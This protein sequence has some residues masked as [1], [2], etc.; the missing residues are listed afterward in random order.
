M[1][2]WLG[3]HVTL[4]VS[5]PHHKSPPCQVWWSETLQQKGCFAFNLS[6]ELMW[7]RDQRVMGHYRWAILIISH[8]PAKFG[9]HRRSAR[10]DISFLVCHM[11]LRY[12]MVRELRDVKREFPLSQVTTVQSS[13]IKDLL[14]EE[15]LSFYHVTWR[16]DVVRGSCDI[17]SEFPSS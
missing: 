12:Y 4:W 3:N 16:G 8:H 15:I 13:V 17:M 5:F 11:T 6:C 7:P 10:E 14:E 1:I 9:C 2:T